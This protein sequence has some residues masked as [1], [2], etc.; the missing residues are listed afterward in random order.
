MFMFY[1][2]Q[3]ALQGGFKQDVWIMM[4]IQPLTGVGVVQIRLSRECDK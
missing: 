4:S 1:Y 2:Y 3:P